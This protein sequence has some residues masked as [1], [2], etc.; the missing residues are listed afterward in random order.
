[1]TEDQEI[2]AIEW[3]RGQY[4]ETDAPTNLVDVAEHQTTVAGVVEDDGG[5]WVPAWVWVPRSAY[6]RG[7]DDD[8][9]QEVL[10]EFG[11]AT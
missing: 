7:V 4:F 9:E 11:W 3:A 5:C 2:V 1:M 8:D 10:D 6:D